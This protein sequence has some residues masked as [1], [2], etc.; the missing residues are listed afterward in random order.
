MLR[1]APQGAHQHVGSPARWQHD[2]VKAPL[3]SGRAQHGRLSRV[4]ECQGRA[5]R[6][7]LGVCARGRPACN[8]ERQAAC[9][10]Q[11]AMGA[12]ASA[13]LQGGSNHSI[14][15]VLEPARHG[16][17]GPCTVRK[18]ATQRAAGR[19]SG[20][21]RQGVCA[22]YGRLQSCRLA[23]AFVFQA[24][25]PEARVLEQPGTKTG[26]HPQEVQR[27]GQPMGCPRKASVSMQF[28]CLH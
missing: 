6:H 16:V 5:P 18:P 9:A 13:A 4:P 11:H 2:R 23:R 8:M 7:L 28:V 22:E 21:A 27:P 26:A 14:R 25:R 20:E 24:Q 12:Q 19:G 10:Q 3:L 1:S 15:G 17:H